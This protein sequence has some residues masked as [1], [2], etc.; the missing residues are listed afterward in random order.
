MQ[1]S[2]RRTIMSQ[3]R[4]TKKPIRLPAELEKL[5]EKFPLVGSEK[6]EDYD[7][8]ALAVAT[9]LDPTDFI[10]WIHVR[11]FVDISWELQRER[12]I[13]AAIVMLKAKEA[14]T[15]LDIAMTRADYERQRVNPSAFTKRDSKPK[16]IDDEFELG[17]PE[18]YMCGHRDIDIIDTRIASYLFRRHAVLREIER[19]S[20]SL[21]RKLDK[22]ASDMIDGDFAE[23]EE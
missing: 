13:K 16:V 10:L 23:T 18:G 15:S 12:K 1:K 2:I 20:E 4:V 14:R 3:F 21:A 9:A 5:F 11:E 17:L 7:A 22:A 6:R 19:Y 8:F